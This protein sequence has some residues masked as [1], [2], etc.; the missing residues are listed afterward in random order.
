MA[1]GDD[2]LLDFVAQ[3]QQGFEHHMVL[4]VVG[5]QGVVDACREIRVAVTRHAVRVVIT[6]QWVAENGGVAAFEQH[7]RMAKIPNAHAVAGIGRGLAGRGG[8][9]ET[10]K[11]LGLGSA[12]GEC[13]G[14][15]ADGLGGM[16]HA[17]EL[18]EASIAEGHGQMQMSLLGQARG[19][20]HKGA[21]IAIFNVQ[22]HT[23][24][25]WL[26]VSAAIQQPFEETHG[27]LLGSVIDQLDVAP[28]GIGHLRIQGFERRAWRM[29]GQALG[30]RV[31]GLAQVDQRSV[32]G[33]GFLQQGLDIGCAASVVMDERPAEHGRVSQGGNVHLRG[34]DKR[35]HR[36][37]MR[38]HEITRRRGRGD[39]VAPGIPLVDQRFG[40]G[41]GFEVADVRSHSAIS[42]RSPSKFML[43]RS[44][45]RRFCSMRAASSATVGAS[46]RSMTFKSRSKVLMSW[47]MS[48]VASRE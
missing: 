46:N 41:V 3:L 11:G 4:M 42:S 13:L 44:S 39:E 8:G 33:A 30:Q 14:D 31:N 48:R 38:M 36:V 47:A 37:E 43:L 21:A 15:V 7:A 2:H 6:D 27:G 25:S 34:L 24:G 17:E 20:E 5:N 9:K 23:L 12:D 40:N 18:I 29:V 26:V 22:G 10:S 45:S 32:F 19:A 16:A 1:G 28:Q 35:F